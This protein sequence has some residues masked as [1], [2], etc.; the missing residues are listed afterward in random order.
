MPRYTLLRHTTCCAILPRPGQMPNEPNANVGRRTHAMVMTVSSSS[1]Q[2]CSNTLVMRSLGH[3]RPGT[4]LVPS[5][6]R[7][8]WPGTTIWHAFVIPPPP[9]RA[10]LDISVAKAITYEKAKKHN[11]PL[12][13]GAHNTILRQQRR[14]YAPQT[15]IHKSPKTPPETLGARSLMAHPVL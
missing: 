2:Y 9:P 14:S 3:R 4:S 5:R 12:H 11:Q 15:R 1:W 7:G 10:R 6:M 8:Q 13:A